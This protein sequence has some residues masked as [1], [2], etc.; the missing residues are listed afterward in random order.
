LIN[1]DNVEDLVIQGNKKMIR[2]ISLLAQEQ[3]ELQGSTVKTASAS[4]SVTISKYGTAALTA[5]Q[6]TE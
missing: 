5:E 6:K 3:L 4:G 1:G 2:C